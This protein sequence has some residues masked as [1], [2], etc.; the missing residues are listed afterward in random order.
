MVPPCLPTSFRSQAG[1]VGD[2]A[3]EAGRSRRPR[4]SPQ[5]TPA[6]IE[7]EI[8]ALRK[9]THGPR[10]RCR[11]LHDP[12]CIGG[13]VTQGEASCAIELET[14]RIRYVPVGQ[15]SAVAVARANQNPASW[16]IRSSTPPAH[17]GAF[18]LPSTRGTVP[19]GTYAPART[20]AGTP[21]RPIR[22]AAAAG[23]ASR[24]VEPRRG[25]TWS[26]R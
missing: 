5:R 23:C 9:G 1:G 6:W 12:G 16:L 24:R 13:E 20:R 17:D 4:T 10:G 14:I 7:N 8:V 15:S 25:R 2:V 11:G 18:E 3:R 21:D 22:S 26:R 19:W